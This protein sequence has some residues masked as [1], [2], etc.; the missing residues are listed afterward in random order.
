MD[1]WA[2]EAAHLKRHFGPGGNAVVVVGV[3]PG[4]VVVPPPVPSK[5]P[6]SHCLR[7]P[8]P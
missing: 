8:T 4:P 5:P 3:P 6:V 1:D 7:P 2:I